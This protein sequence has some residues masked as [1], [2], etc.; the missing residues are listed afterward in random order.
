MNKS[1]NRHM[2]IFESYTQSGNLPIENNISRIFAI[3]LQ[4]YPSL[5]MLFISS[6]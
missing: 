2:N 4:E 6:S 1:S 3:L 5:L